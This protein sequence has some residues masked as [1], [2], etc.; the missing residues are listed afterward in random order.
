MLLNLGLI[1]KEILFEHE[2]Y[3]N[4]GY[5]CGGIAD[6]TGCGK[7]NCSST[8]CTMKEVYVLNIKPNWIEKPFLLNTTE[9]QSKN[10]FD[11]GG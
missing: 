5:I 11:L 2:H 3:C 8:K 1:K 7:L 10:G 4:Y 9:E 6:E